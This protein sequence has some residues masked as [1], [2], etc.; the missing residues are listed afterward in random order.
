MTSPWSGAAQSGS[1]EY[2]IADLTRVLDAIPKGRDAAMTLRT[3]TETLG[4][5]GR[6]VRAILSDRDGIDYLQARDG[7]LFWDAA[8]LEDGIGWTETLRA[9][10][11]SEMA[12]V[13]R[14]E[15]YA[16][17]TLDRRQPRLIA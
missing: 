16:R 14:R 10:A 4:M 11:Q 12:R 8:F 1:R 13:A 6:T 9:R 3:F 7:D 5:D 2:G 17:T 15:R